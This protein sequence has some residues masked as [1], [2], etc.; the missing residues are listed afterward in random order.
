MREENKTQSHMRCLLGVERIQ[1]K[2][3]WRDKFAL[4][5]GQHEGAS[6]EKNW[7]RKLQA[8][9]VVAQ[10]PSGADV[11]KRRKLSSESQWQEDIQ[12]QGK[13]SSGTMDMTS[14]SGASLNVWKAIR[15]FKLGIFPPWYVA[16]KDH[17]YYILE[18]R[19]SEY[20][21]R[22]KNTT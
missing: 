8:A 7:V 9:E 2:S 12:C 13:K 10:I 6:L 16:F 3:L 15:D 4:R 22:V 11:F 18:K 21:N 1:G 5:S 19:L 20:N 17:S 14:H